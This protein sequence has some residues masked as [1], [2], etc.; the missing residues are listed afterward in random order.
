MNPTRAYDDHVATAETMEMRKA[1]LEMK[2]R[3]NMEKAAITSATTMTVQEV[4]E[5]ALENQ[6]RLLTLL[7]QLYDRLIPVMTSPEMPMQETTSAAKGHS[8]L[9]NVTHQVVDNTSFHQQMVT[10]MLDSLEV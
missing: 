5:Q 7:R 2:R 10:T 6:D 1:E 3:A 9:V 8:M 4:L